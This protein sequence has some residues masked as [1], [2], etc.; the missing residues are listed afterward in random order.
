MRRKRIGWSGVGGA[1]LVGL[2]MAFVAVGS[3]RADRLDGTPQEGLTLGKPGAPVELIEYGDLQCPVCKQAAQRVLP[4]VIR[5]E[6][7]T[8]KAK[9]TWRNFTIINPESG[10]AGAAAIAAGEQGRGWSFVEAFLRRQGEENSNYVSGEFLE[11]VATAAG[12][13]DLARWN[14]D[15]RSSKARHE[16]QA[17]TREAT[18]KLGLVGTPTFAIRGPRTHGLKV[19]GTPG[20]AGPLVKAI[21]E[22]D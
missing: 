10:P 17:T 7:T 3:A 1:L 14:E 16:V 15:R 5:R 12:V 6:V 2:F 21:E 4:G 18:H 11:S 20:S 8:G 19:L 9:L 22:A 13:E